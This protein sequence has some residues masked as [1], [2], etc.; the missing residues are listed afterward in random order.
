M[1]KEEKKEN[2]RKLAVVPFV[3]VSPSPQCTSKSAV[4]IAAQFSFVVFCMYSTCSETAFCTVLDQP[5]PG[6]NGLRLAPV[7]L[8]E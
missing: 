1:D 2:E 6:P 8:C 5:V 3:V 7:R 4:D